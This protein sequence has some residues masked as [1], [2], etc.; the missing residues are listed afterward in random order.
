MVVVP[1]YIPVATP[2]LGSTYA[3]EP[4]TAH[5]VPPAGALVKFVVS[6][7]HIWGLPMMVS[8]SGFTVIMTVALQPVPSAYVIYAVPPDIPVTNPVVA[9]IVA[10]VMS[11]LAHVPPGVELLSVVV[12]P[13]H[14]CRL[15][16]M[17]TGIGFTVMSL[18]E[19]QPVDNV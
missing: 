8:G 5:Q 17:P 16:M 6:P 15:P 19:K 12:N 3:G 13:S 7:W 18:V 11:L 14:T 9:P 4:G 10:F 1:G 2:L